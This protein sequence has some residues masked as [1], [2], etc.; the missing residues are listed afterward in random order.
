MKQKASG[1]RV[2]PRYVL[3]DGVEEAGQ[4]GQ[5]SKIVYGGIT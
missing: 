2:V 3:V 5:I 4:K 1:R